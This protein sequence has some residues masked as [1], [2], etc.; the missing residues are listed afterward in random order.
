MQD[1]KIVTL[2]VI[3]LTSILITVIFF[4]GCIEDGKKLVDK[5]DGEIET[6]L[7][8]SAT[9]PNWKIDR[10][11]DY[12]QTTDMLN[13]FN[14]RYPD[15]VDVSSIGKSV[16]G[17]DIWC[18]RITNEKNNNNKYSCLIDGCIHGSEWEAGEACLYLAEFLLINYGSN[19]TVEDILNNSEIY[20]IPILNPDGRE[21][22]ER[23]NDN[24]IDLNRNFDAHFGR[25]KSRNIRLG[26]LFG[27]I[28]KP[29]IEFPIL[30]KLFGLGEYN[31][32]INCGRQA[33]SEP[34]TSAYRDFA[35]SLKD[36]SFYVACHTA[37]YW[38]GSVCNVDYKPEFVVTSHER[39]VFNSVLDWTDKN[40]EYPALYGE[41]YQHAG[42][43]SA[44]D[45]FF[46]KFHI[47]SFTFEILNLDYEP[48][49]HGGGSHDNLI[50]WM[51][52]TLPVFIYLL[53]N[54]ENLHDWETTDIQPPLPEGVPPEPLK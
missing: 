36:L 26:N 20:I 4:T 3:F 6:R 35:N 43:G 37:Q 39:T 52:S 11:H 10:Y 21:N 51:K 30:S 14:D 7:D 16:M 46:K 9:L 31:K 34:E 19:N 54:I 25:L 17:K 2:K 5:Y 38:I 12:Y 47:V 27:V 8:Q 18:I 15:L 48:G 50:H 44:Q 13:D 29:I 24:A 40:T 1:R 28:K 53:V 33:F 22:N 32:Y 45:W 42:F 49:Y 41:D 23:W